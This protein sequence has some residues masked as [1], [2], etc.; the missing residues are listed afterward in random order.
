[1]KKKG[2]IGEI[3]EFHWVEGLILI[4]YLSLVYIA[5]FTLIVQ[6]AEV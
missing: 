6:R 2:L 5:Y 4:G 1:M 3:S